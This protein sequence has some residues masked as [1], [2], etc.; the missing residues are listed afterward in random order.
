MRPVWRSGW[1]MAGGYGVALVFGF[2]EDFLPAAAAVVLVDVDAG[3]PLGFLDLDHIVQHVPDD[4][5]LFALGA[6]EDDLVA[7]S[8]AG[9][10]EG[11]NLVGDD[12]LSC[13]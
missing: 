9:G 4:H 5:G 13:R 2:R 10:G 3:A 12:G 11:G 8:V 6:D 1:K 7:G